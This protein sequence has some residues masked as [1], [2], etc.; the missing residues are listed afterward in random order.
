VITELAQLQ[1]H[2]RT[3]TCESNNGFCPD[4]IADHFG[5][6]VDPFFQHLLLT[7]LAVA[8]GFAIS[9]SLALLAYRRRWLINPVT[10]V[11]GILYTIPSVAA[12][13]LLLPITGRGT[14]TALVALVSYVLLIIFRNVLVGLDN[15]PAET[16]DAARGMGLTDSEL[17]WRVEVPLALPEIMAGLRIATTTTVGPATL[18]FFAGAGGLGEKIFSDIT[19]KSNVV[20]AGGLAV[21]LAAVLDGLILLTQRAITPWTR[22]VASQ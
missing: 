17:L 8:I 7:V 16:K 9:F 21:L 5:D 3:D 20:V 6:Y 12:F 10:Q 19:Y 18:A 4:W 15:V 22:A 14:D 11:T 13:F 1:I 2:E